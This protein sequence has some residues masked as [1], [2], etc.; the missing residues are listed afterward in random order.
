MPYAVSGCVERQP[1]Q[2]KSDDLVVA[3][4]NGVDLTLDNFNAQ[5]QSVIEYYAAMGTDLTSKENAEQN[6]Q[7]REQF[8]QEIIKATVYSQKVEEYGLNTYTEEEQKEL[9]RRAEDL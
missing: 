5:Y 7:L 9:T 3:T 6:E 8:L 4:I 1:G 2:A